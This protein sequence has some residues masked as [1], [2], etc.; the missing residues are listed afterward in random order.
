[1]LRITA[2]FVCKPHFLWRDPGTPCTMTTSATVAHLARELD[3]ARQLYCVLCTVLV[4]GAC[5]SG[6]K[7]TSSAASSADATSA[8]SS[9]DNTG[10]GPNSAG[11]SAGESATGGRAGRPSQS[12]TRAS[13]SAGHGASSERA[14]TE[15]AGSMSREPG[16]SE[17]KLPA[18][19]GQS[20]AN[21][22]AG[23]N[24]ATPSSAGNNEPATPS[25]MSAGCGKEPAPGGTVDLEV[26]GMA[27]LYIVDVPASYDINKPY[28]LIMAFHGAGLAAQSFRSFFKLTPATQDEAIVAYLEA[29]GNPTG[30]DYKRDI[31]Y[32]DAVATQLKAQYCVDESRIFATGHSSGGY[33]TNALGCQRGNVL[34]GIGPFSGGAAFTANCQDHVAAWISHGNMDNIVPT[35]E[36]RSAR[37]LW[38]KQSACDPSQPMPVEPEPCVT[39]AGCDPDNPV[40]YCEYDGD[41]NLPSFGVQAVWSFFKAL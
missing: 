27:R 35:M 1:M 22:D 2:S 10:T 25:M 15:A 28:R 11:K 24:S 40:H 38:A 17:G 4:L 13:T 37:D 31:P 26:D 5:G 41:H 9:P 32:F 18:T 23:A 21:S 39:Y 33:F 30:W 14:Q 36:G 3:R 20:G 7:D 16:S 8:G 6:A 29:L 19:A 12:G 34:R